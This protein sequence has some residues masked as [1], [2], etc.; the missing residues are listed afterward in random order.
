MFRLLCS[1]LLPLVVLSDAAADWPQFRGPS[2]DGHATAKNLPTK[3][4]ETTNVAWKTPIPGKAW[5]SPALLNNRLYLTTAVPVD[6]S[7]PDAVQSLRALCVD[8]ASGRILWD[9]EVFRP[10]AT[11]VAIHTKN[12]HAS[13]TPIVE[14]G[15]V[16][17]HFGHY[18]TTCLDLAGKILW[19]DQSHS[20][21]PVH[22]NGGSPVLVDGLLIFSCDGADDPFVVALDAGT[23]REQWRFSR[24][25]DAD[26]KFSFSTPSVILVDGQRQLI[27]AGSGVVNALE[28]TTG[29]EIWQVRY[30]EGYSV[31][32]KPVFG[33]G[34]LFIATGYNS[35]TVMAIRPEGAKGDVTDTNVVWENKK[36]APH[37]PSLLLVGEELYMVSDRGVA[38]CLDA[39]TGRE[40]W[41]QRIG[42]NYSASPL[43]ADGKIYIQSEEGPAFVLKPGTRFV[44]LSETGFNQSTLASYAVGDKAFF[45]RTE[46]SLYRVESR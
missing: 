29:R 34:L 28:P 16:Y 42:G 27:T 43:Y 2:G 3:W 24:T 13:P 21:E 30:G 1:S 4:N 18:G 20:Y 44:Q 39:R 10:D 5:S 38:T 36:A 35:P 9:V 7:Q 45:I 23:G 22:G 32:P 14:D 26:K 8:A 12:S 6:V 31:I 11:E 33:H 25:S 37:T 41:T 15:R 17:I 40:H 19:K 46:K